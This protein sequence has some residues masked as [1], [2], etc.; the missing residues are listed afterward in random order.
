MQV[1][2]ETRNS[3]IEG[4][5]VEREGD[6]VDQNDHAHDDTDALINPHPVHATTVAFKST[7]YSEIV[8]EIEV[9][10]ENEGNNG[11]L[12]EDLR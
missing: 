5:R 11:F 3:A 7:L 4:V 9:E 1:N 10:A 8:A 6:H 12:I 2:I